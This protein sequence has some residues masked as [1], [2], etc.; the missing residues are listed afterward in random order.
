MSAFARVLS[1]ALI[2]FFWQGAVIGVLLWALLVILRHR[3]AS[4]RYTVSC[5]ALLALA[6]LPVLTIAALWLETIAPQQLF[7]TGGSASAPSRTDVPQTMLQIW[8]VAEEPH[9]A[10]LARIQQWALPLWSAGVL[11]LSVR[12]A[13]GSAR[14]LTLERSDRTLPMNWRIPLVRSPTESESIVRCGS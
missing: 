4:V 1:S 2:D 8:L 11:L 10:W 5:A 3:S 12:L 6:V 14:V 9:I 13:W 7:T